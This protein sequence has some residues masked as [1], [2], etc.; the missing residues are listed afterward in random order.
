MSRATS[1]RVWSAPLWLSAASALGLISAL[2][3]DGPGDVLGW[4]ALAIPV[5]VVAW[6]MLPSV[7]RAHFR[8]P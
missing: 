3:A 7:Q 4:L 8:E 6:C 2:L 5:I 1:I